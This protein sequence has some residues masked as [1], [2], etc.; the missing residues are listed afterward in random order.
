MRSLNIGILTFHRCI[1]Y[2]SYWQTRCLADG[3]RNQGH[4]VLILDHQSKRINYSEWKCA[5]QPVLPSSVP[6]E[7]QPFYREKIHKFFEAFRSLPLSVPFELEEPDQMDEYDTVVVGSDEVW[8]LSHPWYGGCP[9]FF[10]EGIRSAS[11]VAY[12]AS[13][14]N[15]DSKSG[16][17]D[18]WVDK[19]RNFEMVSVRDQ[20]SRHI[21][22]EHLGFEPPLVLDPCLQFPIT[23]EKRPMRESYIAVYG[24]NFSAFF[25]KNIREYARRRNLPLLS[26]GYRND[27]ADVQWL[28]AGPDDFVNFMEQSSGVA[29]N[30]FHGCVFS[31]HFS[32]SFVCERSVYRSNKLN[33]LLKS[34]AAGNH[35][36]APETSYEGYESCLS[37]PLSPQ[38]ELKIDLL[39]QCSD[40]FLN[41][42]L[43][44]PQT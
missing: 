9:L 18:H 35:L 39:R 40:D 6:K 23:C 4:Q 2:G 22:K 3:L 8:N 16:L 26:I 36:M 42:A 12:A 33:G 1:N 13:F 14:G 5:L 43:R 19:L 10:G 31:L 37:Q 34:V 15:Y 11:L 17:Q 30:F 38:V 7:D 25:I 28:N 27:W 29:T 32:R 21:I 20:N 44:Q 24:H 41:R